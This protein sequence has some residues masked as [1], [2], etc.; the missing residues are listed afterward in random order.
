MADY[1]EQAM[2]DMVHELDDLKRKK[3]FDDGELRH[4]VKRRREFEYALQKQPAKREDFLNYIRYEVA[5]EC[6]RKRKSKGLHWKSKS[7]S[8][9]AGVRRLHHIFERGT[10]KFK[11]DLRFWYQYVDFCLRSGSTK[12]LSRVVTRALKFHPREVRLW[13]LA[14]DRE[15]KCGNIKA[16][17]A[18]LL[19]GLRFAPLSPKLWGEFLRLES[20]VACHLFAARKTGAEAE[21]PGMEKK[22][23]VTQ[24]TE[25]AFAPTRLLL[26]RALG[27]MDTKP[28]HCAAFLATATAVLA[29]AVECVPSTE[30]MEQWAREVREAVATRR[31]GVAEGAEWAPEE[32]SEEVAV[33]M[34][35]LWWRQERAA[36]ATWSD[37]VK[38]ALASAPV[39]ALRHCAAAVADAACEGQDGGEAAKALLELSAG[40]RA[41]ENAEAALAILELLERCEEAGAGQTAEASGKLMRRAA[42]AH[43]SCGRLALLASQLGAGKGKGAEV[44]TIVAA[45][46]DMSPPDAARLLL[47]AL[48]AA[49]DPGKTLERLV[50]ALAKDASPQLLVEAFLGQATARG[51]AALQEGLLCATAVASQLWDLP[52]KRTKLLAGVLDVLLRAQTPT[53]VPAKQVCDRFEELLVALKDDEDEKVEWWTRYVAFAGR[54]MRWGAGSAVPVTADL[55]MRALRSVADQAAYT[56]RVQLLSLSGAS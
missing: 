40:P 30:G 28:Q 14:A 53:A 25:N 15:L 7:V 49:A 33:A 48:E 5:L 18:L 6:L 27:R 36:G 23:E 37:V 46:R 19:R 22:A 35:E 20:R 29:H 31:P 55:H 39:A 56:E 16:S 50:R 38:A 44:S 42:A 8:D 4:I 45:A 1:V 11:G 21:L 34:W 51:Q 24:A 52:V 54:A 43:P 13:L 26:R 47:V 41:A 17:R 12:V 9:F 10:K 3:I 2:Q 32:V